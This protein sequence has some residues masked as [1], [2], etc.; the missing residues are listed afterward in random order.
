MKKNTKIRE[1]IL[2]LV[3]EGKLTY[4]QIAKRVGLRGRQWVYYYVK[5][6][7]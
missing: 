5:N 6:E 2:K 4:E 1:R 7:K 3:A